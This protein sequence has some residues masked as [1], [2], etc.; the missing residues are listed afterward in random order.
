[1]SDLAGYADA[2]WN[3][4]NDSGGCSSCSTGAAGGTFRARGA[5]IEFRVYTLE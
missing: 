4:R 2:E 5:N 3:G 1:V